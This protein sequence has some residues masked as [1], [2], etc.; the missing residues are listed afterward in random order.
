M[1]C[2]RCEHRAKWN[3]T[4]EMRPRY[5]CGDTSMSVI[6]CYMFKPVKPVILGKLDEDDDRPLFGPPVIAARVAGKLVADK[7]E[8][9]VEETDD[10]YMLYWVPE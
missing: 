5:Q 1:L 7:I 8:L 3:E 4:K 10:G 2:Y 6:S 9:T